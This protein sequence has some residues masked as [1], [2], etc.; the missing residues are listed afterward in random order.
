MLLVAAASKEWVFWVVGNLVGLGIGALGTAGRAM[1]GLFS[2]PQKSAEFFGFYGIAHKLAAMVGLGWIT[3]METVYPGRFDVV[4][5]SA[6]IFFAGGFVAMLFVS[7]K[8]GR[9]NALRT[10]ICDLTI[11][12][13]WQ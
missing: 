6:S 5:G 10:A 4:V 13:T 9:I 3:L 7:E 11:A 1:V 2:P 8:Q 12:A